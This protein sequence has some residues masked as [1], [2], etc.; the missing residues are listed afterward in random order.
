MKLSAYMKTFALLVLC[1][2]TAIAS[3]AQTFGTLVRFNNIN[4]AAP[5]DTLTQGID[6]DL[7]GTTV[8]GDPGTGTYCPGFSGSCGTVFK[9]TSGGALITLYGFDNNGD[10][11]APF[12]GLTLTTDGNFYGTTS[13]GGYHGQMYGTVF[14]IT[15]LGALTTLYLFCSQTI[16]ALEPADCA[17]APYGSL[18]QGIDGDFYGTTLWGGPPTGGNGTVFKI[19]PQGVL[20]GLHAFL[21]GNPADGIQP[22]AG[23]AQ[24]ADGDFYGSTTE[25]G[26]NGGGTIFRITSTGKL[27]TIFSFD[28]TDG[29]QPEAA[30]VLAN[31]GNFYG[32][33]YDGGSRVCKTFYGVG[34]GTI[35]RITPSGKLTTLYAFCSQPEK[36]DL[37]FTDGYNPAGLI[38]GTDGNFYGTTYGGGDYACYGYTAGCGTVF[39]MTPAGALTTLHRFHGPDGS[40]PTAGLVQATSGIFYGTTLAGNAM[41]DG[42]YPCQYGCGTIYRLDMGLVPFVGF[43]RPF[44]KPGQTG[45]VLGQGFTGTTSVMLNGVP[46]KFKVVSDTYLTATVPPG[47][48][49]GYVTVTTPTGVL[50]S[51]VPFHVIR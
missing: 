4:G 19:T 38:Q 10:G 11:Y 44:G 5:Y 3:S 39:K 24:G 14:K 40:N 36:P 28:G 34:C 25:D 46:A 18:V 1:A 49:T 45:G 33:T 12:A 7:Y 43:V 22:Y 2:A 48:T 16:V 51:N 17:Y 9:I 31:D 42:Y 6:G 35:F 26:V 50:T 8:S 20:I 13:Y 27:T 37:A 23:L 47:A 30:L 21:A 29:A 32:T 15:P 41:S